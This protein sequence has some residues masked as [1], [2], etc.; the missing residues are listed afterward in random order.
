MGS[1]G[2]GFANYLPITDMNGVAILGA[3]HLFTIE[4]R[5]MDIATI[6][7]L[8]AAFG[9]IF[10]AISEKQRLHSWIPLIAYRGSG[11]DSRG[12]GSVFPGRILGSDGSNGRAFLVRLMTLSD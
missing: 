5:F 1:C 10:M 12:D 11:I 8:L 6:V 3:G 9:L 7:G 4:E 2:G